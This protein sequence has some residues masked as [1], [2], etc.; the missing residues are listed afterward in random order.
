M[1]RRQSER[2]RARSHPRC[3]TAF[4]R[5]AVRPLLLVLICSSPCVGM[6]GFAG[7][8]RARLPIISTPFLVTPPLRESA[9]GATTS[10]HRVE[11]QLAT[12]LLNGSKGANRAYGFTCK[13]AVNPNAHKA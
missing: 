3:A 4:R 5:R 7:R 10:P 2:R 13:K 11:K 6:V 8:V 12:S 1:T 9:G